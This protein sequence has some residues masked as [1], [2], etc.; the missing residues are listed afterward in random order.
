VDVTGWTAV[1]LLDFLNAQLDRWPRV[2]LF[3]DGQ[4][5]FARVHFVR[6]VV[7]KITRIRAR[8]RG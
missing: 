3:R 1:R 7:K 5:T 4:R 8:V 6:R 2:E